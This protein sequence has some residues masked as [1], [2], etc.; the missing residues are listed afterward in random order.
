[1]K[2]IKTS[3]NTRQYLIMTCKLQRKGF[4]SIDFLQ[5]ILGFFRFT[6]FFH[7]K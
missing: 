7:K 5:V 1:M 4:V 6:H 3:L 2:G